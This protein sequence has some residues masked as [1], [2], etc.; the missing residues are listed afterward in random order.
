MVQVRLRPSSVVSH[1][2]PF[3]VASQLLLI[4]QMAD[5]TDSSIIPRQDK[6]DVDQ[7][8]AW[9]DG[10]MERVREPPCL[11]LPSEASG[12]GRHSYICDQFVQRPI[13]QLRMRCGYLLSASHFSYINALFFYESCTLK[14]RCACSSEH[15]A[16]L[17]ISA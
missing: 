10:E 13:T 6:S 8:F 5:R 4:I 7:D 9:S 1:P 2:S 16:L 14:A 12:R 3:I 17:W 15:R 11:P